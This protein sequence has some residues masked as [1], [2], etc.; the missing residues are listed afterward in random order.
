VSALAANRTAAQLPHPAP[1]R[2]YALAAAICAAVSLSFVAVHRFS[3]NQDLRQL[4]GTIFLIRR[5][6]W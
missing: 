6:S 5:P 2:P 4:S 3:S 1:P